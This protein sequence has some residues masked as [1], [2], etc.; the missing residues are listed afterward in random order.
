[1]AHNWSVTSAVCGPSFAPSPLPRAKRAMA[2]AR[3]LRTEYPNWPQVLSPAPLRPRHLRASGPGV[4][5]FGPRGFA[6]HRP[7]TWSAR[8]NSHP[9]GRT[10]LLPSSSYLR[11]QAV[12]ARWLA[13]PRKQGPADE[14][15][16][17]V[18]LSG[19]DAR[20]RIAPPSVDPLS[21][22]LQ[23]GRSFRLHTNQPNLKR[24]LQ[25]S[26]ALDLPRWRLLAVPPAGYWRHEVAIDAA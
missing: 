14:G 24:K 26:L 8:D 22:R 13:S 16:W 3:A 5:P 6:V 25:A 10:L 4:L 17:A 2:R 21:R 18:P 15:V 23:L 20:Q 19:R 9:R 12:Y 11:E 1:M 7:G